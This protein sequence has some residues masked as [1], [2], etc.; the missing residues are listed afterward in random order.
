MSRKAAN[1]LRKAHPAMEWAVNAVI[2]RSGMAKLEPR[3]I[4]PYEALTRAIIFQQLSGKAAATIH[5]R[6]LGLFG[7]D[8]APEPARLLRASEEKLRSAGV[9]RNKALALKDLAR[10]VKA[11]DVPSRAECDALSDAEIIARLS[12]VR[13]V[14]EWT[15]QMFLLFTLARPDIWP[16]GDLGVRKGWAIA[17]ARCADE[18]AAIGALPAPRELETAGAPLAPFRSYAALYLWRI[19]DAGLAP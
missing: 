2:A 3:D 13:G 8:A 4:S 19:T 11:G 1:A 12:S 18:D 16:T 17:C 6:F 10:R 14:G 9:S 5:G 7:G 15:A